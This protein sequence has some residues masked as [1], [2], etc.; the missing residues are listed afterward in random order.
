VRHIHTTAH[1]ALADA[2]RWGRIARNP[3]DDA[4]PPRPAAVEMSVWSPEQLRAFIGSVRSDRL[5]AAWLLAATT[6]MRRG[7]LLGLRW[8]DLDLDAGVVNFRQIRTVARY[9]VLTLTP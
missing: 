6:G 9:E 5:F 8:T 4:D 3:A 2:V 7:E 1:K